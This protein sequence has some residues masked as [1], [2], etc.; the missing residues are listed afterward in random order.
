MTAT[1]IEIRDRNL[2]H[3]A[4]VDDFSKLEMVLRFNAVD[5]WILDVPARYAADLGPGSGII[6]RRGGDVLLS[7]PVT[8]PTRQWD[9]DTDGL[10]VAGVS[11]DVHLEDRLAIPATFPYTASD[12]DVRTGAAETIMKTY[13]SVNAG[14]AASVPRQF[15]GLAIDTDTGIGATVTGRAR[16]DGLGDLLRSLAVS[17]GDLGFRVVQTGAVLLFIV[18]QPADRSASVKFSPGLGNLES[19]TYAPSAPESDYVIVGGG[20]EGT[21]RVFVEGGDTPQII[22]WNRRIESFRDRRDTTDTVELA[23]SRDEE[24]ANK[25]EKTSLTIVPKDTTAVQFLRD[26]YLGDLVTV[27]VDGSAIVDVVREVK[28]T[29]S[30]DGERIEPTVGTP[31]ATSK[32]FSG[33]FS[34][35]KSIRR[36]LGHLERRH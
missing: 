20:G 23:Q 28:L 11:D 13:V 15:P 19:F 32:P 18:Y 8:A 4:Q 6:V 1:T 35:V 17:G 26:Y 25:A 33:I 22:R 9:K 30:P 16:F 29:L 3:V 10:S 7:G 2:A 21:A 14:P 27:D 12:Y 5:T 31:G 34:A 24:L 36:N